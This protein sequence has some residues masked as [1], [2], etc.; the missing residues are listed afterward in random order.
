MEFDTIQKL[1]MFQT[2]NHY[3]RAIT[4]KKKILKNALRALNKKEKLFNAIF[5]GNIHYK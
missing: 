1:N 3:F 5:T 4:H 2:I